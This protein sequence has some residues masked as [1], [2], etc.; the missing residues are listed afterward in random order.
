MNYLYFCLTFLFCNV[1]ICA[2]FLFF[3]RTLFLAK[4]EKTDPVNVVHTPKKITA[5]K[6]I[7]RE[8]M[9]NNLLDNG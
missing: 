4:T 2:T 3:V 7:K 1:V 5:L 6:R 9:I 8:E